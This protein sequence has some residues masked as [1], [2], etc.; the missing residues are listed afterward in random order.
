MFKISHNNPE[1]PDYIYCERTEFNEEY[2]K[3]DYNLTI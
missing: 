1:S 3:R 2:A